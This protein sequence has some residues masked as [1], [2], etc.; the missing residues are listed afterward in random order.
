MPA[1]LTPVPAS[2]SFFVQTTLDSTEY[3]IAQVY[4]TA[5]TAY[6][7]SVNQT[8]E[9]LFGRPIV[10]TTKYSVNNVSSSTYPVTA[11]STSNQYTVTTVKSSAH[12]VVTN[13]TQY[14][15]IVPTNTTVWNAQNSPS[16]LMATVG[17][18][19]IVSFKTD[20]VVGTE[21]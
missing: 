11:A 8:G 17:Q 6:I 16:S 18:Y 19:D 2:Q 12:V 3:T 9:A 13:V 10:F 7:T 4:P 15:T 14:H 1:P 21:A 5:T 20:V